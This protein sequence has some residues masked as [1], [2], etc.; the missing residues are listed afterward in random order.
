MPLGCSG[1]KPCSRPGGSPSYTL[2]KESESKWKL[3]CGNA[4]PVRLNMFASTS[5]DVAASVFRRSRVHVRRRS[6]E[7]EVGAR[8]PV[9]FDHLGLAEVMHLGKCTTAWLGRAASR[10]EVRLPIHL[11]HLIR[12]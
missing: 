2:S 6:R 9:F 3:G 12:E 8:T 1:R 5:V 4:A 7:V 11:F 10:R